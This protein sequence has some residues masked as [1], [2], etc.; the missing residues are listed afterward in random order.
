[1][2]IDPLNEIYQAKG[3]DFESLA[4]FESL[5][6]VKVVPPGYQAGPGKLVLGHS[7][8][9]LILTAASSVPLGQAYLTT[10]GSQLTELCVPLETPDE[11]PGYLTSFWE[12]NGITVS[13]NLNDGITMTL[14]AYHEDPETG[15]WINQR[16]DE[17]LPADH[18][19]DTIKAIQEEP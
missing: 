10:A 1:M 18:F 14:E 19:G 11:F 3:V 12:S 13:D 15:E 7:K 17:R 6:L 5:G 4:H 16:T 8:G 9:F 2:V